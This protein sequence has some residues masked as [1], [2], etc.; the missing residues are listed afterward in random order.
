MLEVESIEGVAVG[1]S[2]GTLDGFRLG[3]DDGI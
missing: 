2:E 3:S 1:F